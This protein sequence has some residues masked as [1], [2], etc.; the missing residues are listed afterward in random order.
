MLI[1]Y[2]WDIRSVRNPMR[3]LRV[4]TADNVVLHQ[5]LS[6]AN[7]A[8][9]RPNTPRRWSA[10]WAEL[11][12][13]DARWLRALVRRTNG[14]GPFVVIDPA[15]SNYQRPATSLG[16]GRPDQWAVSS[17]AIA[18]QPDL[19]NLW[20]NGG[21]AAQL[22]WRHPVWGRW[23]VTN[24]LPFA[25]RHNA[26]AGQ[27][28]LTGIYFYTRAG[29][30][31]TGLQTGNPDIA[32]SPPAGAVWA[33]PWLTKAGTGAFTVPASC[34]RYGSAVGPTWYEGEHTG[35][36]TLL[37]PAETINRLPARD[38]TLDLVEV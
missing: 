28:A 36:I 1:G 30:Y 31:L 37:S 19:T 7:R 8:T 18:T 9:V 4:A 13:L 2:P 23:P 11:S 25:F 24:G 21:A 22:T 32:I 35:A 38:L 17:G 29:A 12:E 3:G 20:T 6:G 16:L 33:T 34:V 5:M 14:P 15:T 10:S 27:Y 26:P